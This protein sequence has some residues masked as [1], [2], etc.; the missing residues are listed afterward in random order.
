MQTKNKVGAYYNACVRGES[1]AIEVSL[2]F[3]MQL[4]LR[5]AEILEA[6]ICSAMKLVLAPFF[7]GRG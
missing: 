4:T 5:E 2:P 6:H 7:K 3:Q 1:V